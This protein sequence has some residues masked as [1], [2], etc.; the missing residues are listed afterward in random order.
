MPRTSRTEALPPLARSQSHPTRRPRKLPFNIDNML[1]RVASD[2]E[3]F[4][5]AALFELADNGYN[6]AFEILVACIISIR[7]FDE[8]T[9]PTAKRLFDV[10]RTPDQMA[11]LSPA[12]IDKLIRTC[13]FHEPK[14]RQIHA[15]AQRAV[16]EF[17]GDIPCTFD[18]LTRFS[19]VGPKCANLVLGIACNEPAG[20]G[21]D[22]H[23]HRV[24]NRWG[25]VAAPTP[26]KTM[27][28]LQEK[29]P[30]KH[31]VRIN[32]LLVP[33]GKHICTGKMPKCS[34]CPVQRYCRQVGVAVHR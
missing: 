23:V 7:T 20:I 9:T 15:I 4:P 33:F 26:E 27:S 1:D 18:T 22:I 21:V 25:Y 17:G 10:A 13:T 32:A 14:S 11:R 28:Q 5:K 2:V 19:G 6:S 16:G 12:H 29:L 3:A 8:V 34:S 24:T 30:K 31:W